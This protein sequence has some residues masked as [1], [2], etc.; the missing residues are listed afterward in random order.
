MSRKCLNCGAQVTTQYARV[1]SLEGEDD[2]RVCPDCPDKIRG[3][4]GKPRDARSTRRTDTSEDVD[5]SRETSKS[6]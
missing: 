2:V 5:H 3:K 4:G 6:L 1:F